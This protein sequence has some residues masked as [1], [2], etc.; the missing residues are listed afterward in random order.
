M[1][2]CIKLFALFLMFVFHNSCGQSQITV[3]QDTIKPNSTSYAESQ[4]EAIQDKDGNIGTT[5][6]SFQWQVF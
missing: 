5:G 6:V 1:K 3:P 2:K 4:L